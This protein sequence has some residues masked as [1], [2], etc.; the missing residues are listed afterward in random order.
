MRIV[1]MGPPGAGKGTQAKMLQRRLGVPQISTGDMLREAQQQG[2]SLGREAESYLRRGVL[3]PDDVVIS[4]VVERLQAPDCADG[5]IL[6][7]F[8]RTVE[9]ALALDRLLTTRGQALDAV[10][11]VDVPTDEIVRR[12]SGRL[13][14][15][16][17][18]ILDQTRNDPGPREPGA[19]REHVPQDLRSPGR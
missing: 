15:R 6:D 1:M 17:C 3:V 16:D 4:I 8:P 7:G 19:G 2:T 12:L 11:A 9:Q 18:G 13:V 5:F 10:L 14:C